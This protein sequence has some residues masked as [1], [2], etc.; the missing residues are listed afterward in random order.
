M[1]AKITRLTSIY[2][3]A[4]SDFETVPAG[5]TIR[6]LEAARFLRD[7]AENTVMYFR[8]PSKSGDTQAA[9]TN[10]EEL[11][12]DLEATCKT[13]QASVVHL[14]GGRKRKFDKH[15][16]EVVPRSTRGNGKPNRRGS[17]YRG[18][19]GRPAKKRHDAKRDVRRR[20]SVDLSPQHPHS[21]RDQQTAHQR[22]F[23]YFRPVDSYQPGSEAAPASS[24]AH[25]YEQHPHDRYRGPS[26]SA[27]YSY[28]G[29]ASHHHQEREDIS[30]RYGYGEEQGWGQGRDYGHGSYEHG[31]G[32]HQ[33]YGRREEERGGRGYSYSR[34]GAGGRGGEYQ[35]ELGY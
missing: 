10:M 15:D 6:K 7:T 5:D 13:A 1:D 23:G 16:Y 14:S 34:R 30:S 31:H 20:R 8:D 2:E 9:N 3:N 24:H 27:R 29:G 26:E 21:S 11:I 32:H 35:P 4:K 17:A 25:P 12:A 33:E 19:G 22:A 28:E 18:G